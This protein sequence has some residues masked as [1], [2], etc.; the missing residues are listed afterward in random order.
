MANGDGFMLAE[1]CFSPLSSLEGVLSAH[2][3]RVG[4]VDDEYAGVG[5]RRA[6]NEATR[7]SGFDRKKDAAAAV[8]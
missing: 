3:A 4:K 1:L 5:E 8:E 2:P 6:L 7:E